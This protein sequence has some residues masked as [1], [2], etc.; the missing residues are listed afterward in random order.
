VPDEAT[1]DKAAADK[2]AAADVPEEPA[3]PSLGGRAVSAGA[4]HELQNPDL[5]GHHRIVAT[6]MLVTFG[7]LFISQG[8]WKSIR[9][10]VTEKT[11]GPAKVS[12]PGG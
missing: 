3:G 10:W 1:D 2:Q 6:A 7:V 9:D 4:G 8:W 5:T 11:H 12:K